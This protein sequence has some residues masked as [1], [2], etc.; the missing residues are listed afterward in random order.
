MGLNLSKNQLTGPIPQERQFST[1]LNSSF[2][3]NLGLCGPPLSRYHS[4]ESE[5]GYGFGF[6]WKAVAIGYG[7][8]LVI[9]L[10]TGYVVISRRPNWLVRTF[11]GFI[12]R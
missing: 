12:L 6:G 5:S 8:G 1:F 10:I 4:Q 11:G 2:E 7:C 9:G 3:G